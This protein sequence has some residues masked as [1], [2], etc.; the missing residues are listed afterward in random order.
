MPVDEPVTGIRQVDIWNWSLDTT[1]SDDALSG[2]GLSQDELE[3]AQRFVKPRD[4]RRYM[5]GRAGLR[6]ILGD[7][8]GIAP[9]DVRFSYTEFGKPH[10]DTTGECPLEF[11][12]SHS[13][14]QAL[15]AVS[16]NFALGVDIEE[17]K[18]IAED[19]A[20]HF[21]SAAECAELRAYP[22]VEQMPAFYRCW[23]RKEAFVKAHGAGLSL[24]LDCFD[25]SLS[26]RPQRILRRLDPAVGTATDWTITNVGV[27]EGFCAAV[28]ILTHGKAVELRYCGEWRERPRIASIT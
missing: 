20:G 17:I 21:F 28:A 7:Y 18:P 16:R 4:A 24:A 6:S 12:L 23:T 8:L 1:A 19:V 10:L 14:D 27:A 13:A 2:T 25:V 15:L 11:N 9:K 3:R 26:A 22:P 5:A